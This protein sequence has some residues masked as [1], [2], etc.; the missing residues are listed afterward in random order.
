V[1][2]EGIWE[3]VIDLYIYLYISLMEKILIFDIL[4]QYNIFWEKVGKRSGKQVYLFTEVL[5]YPLIL[6]KNIFS[7][8]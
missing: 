6:E 3:S 8:K 7:F 4:P 2:I 1:K 5:V